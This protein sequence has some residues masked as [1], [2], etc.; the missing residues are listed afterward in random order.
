MLELSPTRY[1]QATALGLVLATGLLALGIDRSLSGS[2]AW[3]VG[4]TLV[5][6]LVAAGVLSLE[7]EG[8]E[9]PSPVL[10]F[11][12]EACPHCDEARAILKHLQDQI[13]FDLWEVDITGD[14]D[15]E[16]AYG[17]EVPVVVHEQ[18]RVAS[19]EVSEDAMRRALDPMAS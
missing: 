9:D 15:L 10:L 3:G 1:R 8:L 14:E 11:T 7:L 5:G 12:R 16:E 2:L 6:F 19:L 13:G 18:E 17:T 4:S